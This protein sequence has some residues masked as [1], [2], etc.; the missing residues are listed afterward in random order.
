MEGTRVIREK[1]KKKGNE[2]ENVPGRGTNKQGWIVVAMTVFSDEG[3]RIHR[4]WLWLLIPK[5]PRPFIS[6]NY[7]TILLISNFAKPDA[8]TETR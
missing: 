6:D 3:E 1:K 2:L 4:C 5:I 8:F 7:A